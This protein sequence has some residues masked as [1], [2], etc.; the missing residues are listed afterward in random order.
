MNIALVIG[1]GFDLSLG[2]P[3]SFSD[4][5]GSSYFKEIL[6]NNYLC[7][8]MNG[9]YENLGWVDIE[10]ELADYSMNNSKDTKLKA[11]YIEL[12]QALADYLGDIEYNYHEI[13]T[14]S[15]AY[16]SFGDYFFRA[17]GHNPTD[18]M[19]VINFNYTHSIN[20]LKRNL[21]GNGFLSE[22]LE[23]AEAFSPLMG[24]D[25][26]FANIKFIHPHGAVDTGIVFGVDDSAIISPKHT[27]L[28]K[29]CCSA[30]NPFNPNIL[31]QADKVIIWGHS[32]GESDHGY[33]VDFFERQASGKSARK[34]I[35]ITYYGEDG[36]DSI[37]TQLDILTNH[38]IRGLKVHNRLKLI[39]SSSDECRWRM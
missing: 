14:E 21:Y 2:L 29:S 37:I 9:L 18:M 32:L 17:V 39:D 33:F 30:F 10:Y 11:E 19:T 16:L 28:R 1:N 25:N 20:K 3:T 27:F 26:P 36:Y 7:Q 12:Q 23:F 6:P 38:N 15:Q 22:I 8:H 13:D 34:E 35:V 5:L 24:S 31:H 4:F